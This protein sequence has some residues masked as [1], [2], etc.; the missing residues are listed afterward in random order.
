[1]KNCFLDLLKLRR[2]NGTTICSAIESFL[3]KKKHLPGWMAVELCLE[4]TMV[5]CYAVFR[6]IMFIQFIPSLHKSANSLLLPFDT[7]IQLIQTMWS[8]IIKC[9]SYFEKDFSKIRCRRHM[10]LHL[11]NWWKQFSTAGWAMVAL[12]KQ[13]CTIKS[14]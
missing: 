11:W 12:Y 14:L 3:N 7:K 13:C 8:V 9:V 2:S 4:I 10:K 1:M 6:R 5:W